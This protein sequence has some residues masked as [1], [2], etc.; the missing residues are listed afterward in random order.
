MGLAL[1][2]QHD[3]E[4][5][6]LVPSQFDL[7]EA[8]IGERERLP[9]LHTAPAAVCLGAG[10]LAVEVAAA[11]GLALMRRLAHGGTLAEPV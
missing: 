4:P 2:R 7:S 11:C 6:P 10:R 5:P 3:H 9:A 1:S 8:G